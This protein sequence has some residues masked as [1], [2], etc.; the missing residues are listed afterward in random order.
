MAIGPSALIFTI[1]V[2]EK[3]SLSQLVVLIEINSEAEE[4]EFVG[5]KG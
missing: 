1:I 2:R 5:C 4:G 3:V